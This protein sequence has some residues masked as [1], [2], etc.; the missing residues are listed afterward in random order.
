MRQIGANYNST[1]N[2]FHNIYHA[3]TVLHGAYTISKSEAFNELFD[4][5]TTLTYLIAA[6]CHDVCHT[7]VTNF[8][9][10]KTVSKLAN[11]YGDISIL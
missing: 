10:E 1:E 6:Y 9:E 5:E 7:G 8:F 11:R 4:E 2:V 3:F